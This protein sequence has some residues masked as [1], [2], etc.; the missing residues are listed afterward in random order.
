[1]AEI[2]DPASSL[3]QDIRMIRE[4][5]SEFVRREIVPPE[6][7]ALR[8]DRRELPIDVVARLQPLA[9]KAG[10]WYL[11]TP[12]AVGGAGL[13]TFAFVVAYEAASHHAFCFPDPGGGVFGYDLPNVLH[14]ATEAQREKY[15]R[16]SV[17]EARQWFF[18]ISEPAGGSDPAR[19]IQT[20]A[21][22]VGNR[23]VLSG[24]KMWTSRADVARHGIVFARTGE[25][26]AGISAFIVDMPQP[27][28]TMRPV[29]VVRDHSTN[30]LLLDDV[31]LPLDNLLGE[32]GAGFA[33]TQKWLTKSRLKVAAQS[34]GAA[35]AAIDIAADYATVRSTFGAL[36]A[37][38][39][40]VQNLLVDSMMEL[41]AA[42][43]MLW[44]AAMRDERGEDARQV[45]SM[46]KLYCTE[47]AFDA[48][49]RAVQ[50][51]GGM[52]LS[53]EMP[54]EHWFRGLRV[55]RIIEGPSEVHRMLLARALLG[56]SALDRPRAA[57]AAAPHSVQ[58]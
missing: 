9:R 11:D 55:T 36:L 35:Q 20:R 52:G 37:T 43:L 18:G 41:H 2:F 13:A 25:G 19:A 22:R 47:R 40:S 26:R 16:V 38:R 58:P 21:R 34:I 44:D 7:Q 17:D 48:T 49:D 29:H 45:A 8:E 57:A 5:I 14:N 32:E 39:Q 1:M 12:E 24:R 15:L 27:G 53:R 23:W 31:E 30:E 3:P 56:E 28:L 51:L 6:T 42:R 33:L 46:A 54:L 4:T 50:V 10:L